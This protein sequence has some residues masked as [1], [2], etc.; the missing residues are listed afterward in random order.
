MDGTTISSKVGLGASQIWT[1]GTD[2]ALTVSGAVSDF[3]AGHSLTK[4]GDGTLTLT[5]D[6]NF[7]GALE[8]AAGTLQLGGAARLNDITIPA[9]SSTTASSASTPPQLRSC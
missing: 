2:A 4:A 7:S 3:G 8:I 9:T 5:S 1:V 6:T